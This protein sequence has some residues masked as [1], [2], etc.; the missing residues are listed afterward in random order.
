M[1]AVVLFCLLPKAADYK[2]WVQYAN[3]SAPDMSTGF[4]TFTSIMT[5]P[6]SVPAQEPDVLYLFPAVQS[7]VSCCTRADCVL[8]SAREVVI[9]A[10]PP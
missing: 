1:I 3:F 9:D 5:V 8:W 7:I 6:N 10:G 2:G 4:D